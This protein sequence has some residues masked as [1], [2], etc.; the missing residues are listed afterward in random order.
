VNWKSKTIRLSVYLAIACL[1]ASMVWLVSTGDEG[2][3]PKEGR[4]VLLHGLGRSPASMWL[5]EIALE[6][7]GFEVHNIGY[8]STE[9]SFDGLLEDLR[10]SLAACCKSDAV[11]LHFVT[12]SLGGL[13]VRGYLA[14]QRPPNLGRVV[15]L[16]PPNKGSEIV[17]LLG[18]EW[19]F[20]FTLGPTGKTL[21]TEAGDVPGRLG[22]VD[23]P[24]GIIAGTASLNPLGSWLLPGIHDGTVSAES[25]KL[26]G[27]ADFLLLP[28]SHTFIMNSR[29]VADETIYFLRNGRFTRSSLEAATG[30]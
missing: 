16:A 24:L 27:M 12:H 5:M 13:L 7:A 22:P 23:F 28:H 2:E 21:G 10:G 1:A 3:A 19:L 30:G 20:K 9:E 29:T 26:D 8:P 11:P 4:V 18:D 17:D 6:E 25:A 14:E 15:M